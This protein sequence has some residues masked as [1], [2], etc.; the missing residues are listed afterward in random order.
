V[1]REGDVCDDCVSAESK[2][3]CIQTRFLVLVRIGRTAGAVRAT[4]G[5]AST[6]SMMP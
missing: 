3:G 5:A 6:A 4:A 1:W 2:F